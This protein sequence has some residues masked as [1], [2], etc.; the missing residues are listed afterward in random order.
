MA[1][2]SNMRFIKSFFF[3]QADAMHDEVGFPRYLVEQ[4]KFKKRFKKYDHVSA[5]LTQVCGKLLVKTTESFWSHFEIMK[6]VNW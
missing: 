3:H 1:I 4:E 5:I 2:Q 6:G